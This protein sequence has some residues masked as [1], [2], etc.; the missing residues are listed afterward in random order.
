MLSL[1]FINFN[2]KILIQF[3]SNIVILYDN[4]IYNYLSLNELIKF[5]ILVNYCINLPNNATINK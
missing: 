3:I 4:F 1:L 5:Y 2:N